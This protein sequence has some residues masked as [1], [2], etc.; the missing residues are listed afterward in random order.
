MGVP[1]DRS[2]MLIRPRVQLIRQTRLAAAALI[3]PVF[4][5][6]LWFSLPRGTWLRVAIA[7]A[8]VLALYLAGSALLRGVSIRLGPDG[9]VE[10]GFFRRQSRIPA[11]RIAAAVVIDVYRGVTAE[12]DRQLFLV[13]TTGELLVRMRGE[14]WTNEAIETVA[15]AFEVPVR[16][17]PDPI[18]AT[19]LRHDHADLLFWFERWP[20]A[21]RL[22]IAGV[23]ALLALILIALMSPEA[24]VLT[25]AAER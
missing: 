17:A 5:A 4:A 21:G 19:Q 10:R 20:W 15:A 9:L 25:P 11:K 3:L 23:I 8:F 22:T 1:I 18:T 6:M 13:D 2:T 14:F 24:L 16:R 12:T 7:F